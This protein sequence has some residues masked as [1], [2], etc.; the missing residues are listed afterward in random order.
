MPAQTEKS[1]PRE[2]DQFAGEYTDPADPGSPLSFYVEDG[3]LTIES[4]RGVPTE[5]NPV[6]G[7][8]FSI[9]GT[10]STVR[11]TL[12]AVGEGAERGFSSAPES[13]YKRTGPAVR[14]IFHDY[15]RTEA[16]ILM[17]DG[18]KL[19][20]VI[21]KP[22]DITTPLPFLLQRTPYGVDGTNRASFF[23]SRPELARDG[24][25]YVCEDIAVAIK[26]KGSL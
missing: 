11:F 20:A 19:H 21:L 10:R 12:D 25:I 14:H 15:Q 1:V 24:Y 7:V 5:L 16:M 9:S 18:V 4:E 22:A 2:L 3:R 6:S 23:A 8:E 17:R 26:A 13:V